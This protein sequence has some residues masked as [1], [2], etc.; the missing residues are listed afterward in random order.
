M[1]VPPQIRQQGTRFCC[2]LWYH[3]IIYID[4]CK[5]QK[6]VKYCWFY[7]VQKKRCCK[8]KAHNSVKSFVLFY[9]AN[10]MNFIL[11]W[12][13]VLKSKLYFN[14]LKRKYFFSDQL[15]IF[16][17]AWGGPPRTN[18]C[19]SLMKTDVNIPNLKVK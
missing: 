1:T 2:F 18:K 13:Y 9:F 7:G 12:E 11:Q 4:P 16:R 19:C 10:S 6:M 3:P 5:I 14:I 17:G 15:Q 8:R